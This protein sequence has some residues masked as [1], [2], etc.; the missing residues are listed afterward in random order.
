MIKYEI[1]KVEFEER[2]WFE[3]NI[4]RENA[5]TY[6]FDKNEATKECAKLNF[7]ARINNYNDT[8]YYVNEYEITTN[9]D[10]GD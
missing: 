1:I 10:T 9:D 3:E 5:E 8:Y 6:F 4:H 7:Y 2:E